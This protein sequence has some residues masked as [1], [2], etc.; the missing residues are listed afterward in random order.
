MRRKIILRLELGS[1]IKHPE[2][3][4]ELNGY[5]IACGFEVKKLREYHIYNQGAIATIVYEETDEHREKDVARQ[6]EKEKKEG[7]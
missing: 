7:V 5:I 6:A 1:D 2:L 3:E 4:S